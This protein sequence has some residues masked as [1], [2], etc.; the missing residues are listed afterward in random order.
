MAL[1]DPTGDRAIPRIHLADLRGFSA[2]SNRAE[3]ESGELGCLLCW[4]WAMDDHLFR[5]EIGH[6][7]MSQFGTAQSG[8]VKRHQR[9]AIRDG[10]SAMVHGL[11]KVVTKKKGSA[12][13]RGLTV[14]GSQ[15]SLAEQIR[16]ILAKLLRGE[17]VGW[18][19]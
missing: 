15:L 12:A 5:V 10:I 6:F 16:L 11:F 1:L 13:V 3:A 18:R 9:Q 17:L 2:A 4:S 14:I 19:M 8:G 7:E